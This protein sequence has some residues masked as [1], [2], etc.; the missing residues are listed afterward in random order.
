[1]ATYFIDIDGTV[2]T[3]RTNDP[4]PGALEELERLSRDGHQIIFTTA[5]GKEW[6][7]HPIYDPDKTL[8]ALKRLGIK[9][10]RIL[11]DIS[12]PR[13]VVNDQGAYA[14]HHEHN[15]DVTPEEFSM[16]PVNLPISN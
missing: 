7:G 14:I 15:A 1:M 4:L 10:D 3:Q 9:Y 6:I 2:F 16:R 13:V 11:F 8:E 12:S 5:R